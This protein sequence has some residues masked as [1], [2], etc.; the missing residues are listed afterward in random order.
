MNYKNVRET[1]DVV[2]NSLLEILEVSRCFSSIRSNA[3]LESL[4]KRIQTDRFRVLVIGEFSRG[5]S[6]LLNAILGRDLIKSKSAPSTPIVIRINYGETPQARLVFQDD[7]EDQVVSIE[8][9]RSEYQLSVEDVDDGRNFGS[10]S[11]VSFDRF[12]DIDHAV[13]EYPLELCRHGVELIDTPGLN[14]DATRSNRTRKYLQEV[15]AVIMVL[16]ATQLLNDREVNVI[17]NV[18]HPLGLN[19]IFFVVN[20]WN[21]I[22]EAVLK[23]EDAEREKGEL[24]ARISQQLH[25]FCYIDGRDRS[26]DRIFRVNALGALRGRLGQSPWSDPQMLAA[27]GI[28]SFEAALEDFLVKERIRTRG[29]F[30]RN[31]LDN[32]LADW[33]RAVTAQL[34]L[35]DRSVGEIESEIKLI[36]PKLRRLQGLRDHMLNYLTAKSQAL[37]D[38]LEVSLRSHIDSITVDI[39]HDIDNPRYFDLSVL[40]DSFLSWEAIK[41]AFSEEKKKDFER[42]LTDSLV[43]QVRRY[44]ETKI[45]GWQTAVVKN[46]MPVVVTEL[47]KFLHAEIGEYLQVFDEIVG[48][49]PT[50]T[51]DKRSKDEVEK[52]LG[53]ILLSSD[54][55]VQP[56]GG[57]I[58]VIG[59]L[60]WV[61]AGIT[62]SV[63]GLA[64]T[65]S[66]DLILPGLGVAITSIRLLWREG[67]KKREAKQ[68]LI[69]TIQRNLDQ[70]KIRSIPEVRRH[71][72]RSFLEVEHRIKEKVDADVCLVEDSLRTTLAR[73][74]DLEFDTEAEKARLR[75]ATCQVEKLQRV[76]ELH[77]ESV[78][79]VE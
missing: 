28:P 79:D 41:G 61:V 40:T 35:M 13:L 15:D 21:L 14:H 39:V 60:A 1:F 45:G 49:A 43:P 71:V 7:R 38:K 30:I 63:A 5:K 67:K 62:A 3:T 48:R 29:Q 32:W 19:N 74:N 76:V 75:D 66:I 72:L 36:E 11:R 54:P 4:T 69:S 52:W 78:N 51:D 77:L 50:N 2:A 37:Q 68:S 59:D 8:A 58:T 44:L 27:S 46:E 73:K 9:F 23:P 17:E 55:V 10:E 56:L 18:L 33:D 34:Q 6:A 22:D 57:S 24:N 42:R 20:K 53:Q 31:S 70:A 47:R 26:A 16:D 25:P 12:K 65:H 64:L